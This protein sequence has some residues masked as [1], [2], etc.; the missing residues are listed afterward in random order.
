MTNTPKK[1][2][3]KFKA[4]LM[5]SDQPTEDKRVYSK[6]LC[7]KVVAR[8]NEKPYIVIQEMNLVE[9]K[10]K[11]IRPDV[12]WKQKI[13]ATIQ[14]AQL[15]EGQVVFEAECRLSRDGKTLSG[16]VQSLGIQEIEFTPVGRGTLGAN[17]VVN[18]DYELIYISV[19]PLT[20]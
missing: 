15:I 10:L 5:V 9:R 2:K 16:M 3:F 6:A 12:V 19:E 13:M 4:V 7:E 8:L 20:K 18:L 17:G 14:S 11:E 1:E